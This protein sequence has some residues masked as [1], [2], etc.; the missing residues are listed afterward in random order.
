M[1]I[2]YS[3][4]LI[5]CVPILSGGFLLRTL[6]H[7][8]I[9]KASK[10]HKTLFDKSIFNIHMYSRDKTEGRKWYMYMYMYTRE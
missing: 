7:Q 5:P 6:C 10:S 9:T 3:A 4:F 2:A 8:R 1:Y